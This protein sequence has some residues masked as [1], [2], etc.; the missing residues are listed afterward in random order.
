MA[1]IGGG[2]GGAEKGLHPEHGEGRATWICCWVGHVWG[3]K[4]GTKGFSGPA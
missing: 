1:G 2:S 3:R 4:R